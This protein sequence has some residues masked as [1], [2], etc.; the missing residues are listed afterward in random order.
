MRLR[1]D[2]SATVSCYRADAGGR[3]CGQCDA[4]A[5]RAQGFADAGVDDPTRY[6]LL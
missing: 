2:F 5:L 4:C 1:V 3:A 6:R